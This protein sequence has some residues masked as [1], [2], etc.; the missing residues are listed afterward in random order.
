MPAA[1]Q[2]VFLLATNFLILM[3]CLFVLCVGCA[4][5]YQATIKQ[6]VPYKPGELRDPKAEDE[7]ESEEPIKAK[8][9]RV[10]EKPEKERQPRSK[11]TRRRKPVEEPSEVEE[12]PEPEPL[13]TKNL[14]K[15]LS[16][17]ASPLLAFFT[18]GYTSPQKEEPSELS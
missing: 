1:L 11:S 5:F 12:S 9:K 6:L 13:F 17:L 16:Y 18:S 8:P 15:P 7:E 3:Y 14:I 10:K 4:C 2:F